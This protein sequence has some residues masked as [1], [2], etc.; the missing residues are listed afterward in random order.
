[1]LLGLT[2]CLG[3]CAASAAEAV[4]A[5]ALSWGDVVV[6]QTVEVREDPRPADRPARRAP[7]RP[8]VRTGSRPPGRLVRGFPTAAVWLRLWLV[9]VAQEVR[10]ARPGLHVTWLQHVDFH[11]LRTRDG[12]PAWD[13]PA[14]RRVRP[15]G[16]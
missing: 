15:D 13:A 8:V 10:T 3:V 11:S 7:C 1:M 5:S 6:E 2:L 12:Q 9:N 14:G 16:C 4:K